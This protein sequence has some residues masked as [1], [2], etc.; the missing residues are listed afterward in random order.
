MSYG[1]QVTLSY[2]TACKKVQLNMQLIEN[3]PEMKWKGKIF[4]A[5]KNHMIFSTG[6]LDENFFFFLF[7]PQLIF[8]FETFQ[9]LPFQVQQWKMENPRSYRVKIEKL[10]FWDKPYGKLKIRA[11]QVRNNNISFQAR[12]ASEA[13]AS[14]S[15]IEL[16][17]DHSIIPLRCNG[18]F[19][20]WVV[21]SHPHMTV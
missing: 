6:L 4:S 13:H 7:R 11:V 5:K 17:V 16:N 1:G 20:I 3:M 12:R 21:I 2:R 15:R 18:C 9:K 14:Q 19:P 8:P 10:P